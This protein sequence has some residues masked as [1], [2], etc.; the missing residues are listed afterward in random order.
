MTG[1]TKLSLLFSFTILLL[2]SCD[3]LVTEFP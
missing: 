1:K 3:P 2:V